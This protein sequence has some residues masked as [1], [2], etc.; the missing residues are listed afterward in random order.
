MLGNMKKI[1]W[2]VA[3]V[4]AVFLIY[5]SFNKQ[6]VD[7]EPVSMKVV[8]SAVNNS[9]EAGEATITEVDGQIKVVVNLT[10]ALAE[11]PQPAH[12]HKGT[13]VAPGEAIYNL[14]SVVNGESETIIP[15]SK[16]VIIDRSPLSIN[17]HESVEKKTNYVACGDIVIN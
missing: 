17:V 8:L 13:C 9:G 7:P 12:L 15:I 10:G 16:Q 4:L 1:I 14:S 3:I 6:P 11:I 5:K 2:L